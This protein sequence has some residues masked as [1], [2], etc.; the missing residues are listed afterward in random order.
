VPKFR[1][2]FVF[3]QLLQGWLPFGVNPNKSGS[4]AGYQC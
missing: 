4:R 1:E 2:N 3:A